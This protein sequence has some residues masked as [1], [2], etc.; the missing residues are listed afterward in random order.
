M[1]HDSFLSYEATQDNFSSAV[2]A[3]QSDQQLPIVPSSD[4]YG[5]CYDTPNWR[6]RDISMSLSTETT[7]TELTLELTWF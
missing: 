3:S 2:F 4:I 5:A 6:I 7:L 1:E